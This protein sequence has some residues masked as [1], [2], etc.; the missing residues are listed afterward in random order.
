MEIE[1]NNKVIG[2]TLFL[3]IN[4]MVAVFAISI[5][6]GSV[7]AQ[8]VPGEPCPTDS[9]GSSG[10]GVLPSL[11]TA[12]APSNAPN[13]N[14]G[15][16]GV[17]LSD[18]SKGGS[19]IDLGATA[20]PANPGQTMEEQFGEGNAIFNNPGGATVQP[21]DG[22]TGGGSIGQPQTDISGQSG[23]ATG[24]GSQ[25]GV[26]DYGGGQVG[27]GSQQA[28]VYGPDGNIVPGSGGFGPG[29]VPA[30][31]V[32][33]AIEGYMD[34]LM[35]NL[36]QVAMI[37]GIGAAL[38]G[39]AGGKDGT[40]YGALSG[41]AGAIAYQFAKQM[42]MSGLKSGL[43]GLG[44]GLAIFILTYKKESKEIVEFICLPW[45]APIGG[46][47]CEK[48]NDLEE[49][50]E[51]TCKSLG[52]ACDLVN[53]GEKEQMCIWKNPH[54]TNS[55]TIEMKSVSKDHKFFPDKSIRPPAT[56]VEIKNP[57]G[58]NNCI[59][60]FTPLEF[61]FI[62]NEPAQ[63]K[64]DYNLTSDSKEA[65]NMMTYFV[66][67]VSTF[68]YNHTEKLALPGPSAI[69]FEAPELQNDGTYTLYVRCQDANGNFN[70]NPFSVRFCVEK[71]PDTTPPLIVNVSIP[72]RSPVQFNLSEIDLEVY[73]NEP[74]DCKWSHENRDYDQMENE[75]TCSNQL[76]EMNNENT[77]TCRTTLTGI[78]SR[79]E[80]IYYFKCLDKPGYDEADRNV[81]KNSFSYVILGTQPI[82]I[83]DFGPKLEIF[84]AT[85]S[86]PVNLNIKTDN[87]H[88]NGE[89]ICYYSITGDENT[90]IEFS[91]TGTNNH[92]QR[93]DLVTGEYTYYY[94]CVDL[95][96]NAVYNQTSFTVETDKLP[97]FIV[98]TYKES[99]ELKIL[100]HERAE[101]SY[102]F[103]DCN[104]EIDDGISFTSLDYYSH[105]SEWNINKKYY[106]RC[107]DKY[108]NQP[109][110]NVCSMIISPFDYGITSSLSGT[111]EL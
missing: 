3:I 46:S 38:G 27:G 6:I 50:S 70:V 68:I 85:D 25:G 51:Y 56:G 42:G 7:D 78:E 11:N 22:R 8:C 106:V 67:G 35:S 77:Y 13:P 17:S 18:L 71:G 63:C 89:A 43:I 102:S 24:G 9:G 19:S 74:S 69:N 95:G 91:D 80:N 47:D 104:F 88:N 49:C 100:T 107:K 76:W 54:D 87:G 99:G 94:K 103:I 14:S 4:L 55:P 65:F 109:N 83:I 61:E 39:F 90:Y 97:P 36:G 105:H 66:G 40:M 12:P 75:M 86:I 81:N 52:Q 2:K 29:N 59:K 92:T 84:G 73:V 10:G 60:A 23:G 53:V 79:K 57:S 93:Q 82:N 30:P 41:A 31:G 45:Q 26:P 44:V 34:N 96:G 37:G 16:A 62:T 48:C 110:P 28:P 64:I 5:L 98:R 58:A 32:G 72:S 15:Q 111:I 101:C 108:D 1:K 33:G 20:N 21:S